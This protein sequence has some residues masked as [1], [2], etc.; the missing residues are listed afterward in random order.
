MLY[1]LVHGSWKGQIPHQKKL[2]PTTENTA[3]EHLVISPTFNSVSVTS[4]YLIMLLIHM[5]YA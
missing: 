1:V 4:H 5:I 2:R 3:P